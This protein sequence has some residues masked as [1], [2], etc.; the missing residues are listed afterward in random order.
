MPIRPWTAPLAE[1]PRA[2]APAPSLRGVQV[3]V[4]DDD[5]HAREFV[6]TTL[7]QYG[8]IVVTA[9]T[10]E[11]AKARFRRQPPDVFVSDLVMPDEDGLQLIRDIRQLERA[12]GRVTPA[13]AL[14]AL[15]RSDDRRRALSAGYQMHMAKPIDPSEL[16]LAVERLAQPPENYGRHN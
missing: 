14:T 10:A 8:A 15:A 13:A 1:P 9:S 11:E 6:R 3:L 16:V 12:T 2:E 4:V 5:K 7:E